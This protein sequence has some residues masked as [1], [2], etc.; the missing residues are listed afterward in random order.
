ML[1]R[2]TPE[3][4]GF[5]VDGN[6]RWAKLNGVSSDVHRKGADVVFEV[7]RKAIES[8]AKYATFYVFSTENWHRAPEEVNYLMGL[9]VKYFEEKLE[10]LKKE[11]IRIVFLGTLDRLG[12]EVLATMHEVEELTKNGARGTLAFCFNYGGQQELADACRKIVEQ[13]LQPA[14][15][16]PETITANVYH[17]EIPPVDFVVRTGGEQRISNFMLWRLAYSEFLFLD[18]LWPELTVQDVNDIFD[19]FSHRQRR[20]GH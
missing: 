18:K 7:A 11:D 2:V 14:D 13:G 17:P 10:E 6:R 8:G 4:I 15:I 16:T 19:E 9:F 1:E 3:H 5:I 20:F 12:E